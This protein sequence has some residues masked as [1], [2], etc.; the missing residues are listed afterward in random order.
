MKHKAYLS[1][2]SNLGDRIFNLK[3]A[4]QLLEDNPHIEV[5]LKS[6]FYTTA[7]IG[8][9]EQ[10]DFVNIVVLLETNLEPMEL[11]RV[12]GE[13]EEALKRV[14]VIHWGPRTIDLDIL[15]Y[16]GYEGSSER[17]TVPHPRMHERGF[18][19]IPLKELN[20][21]LVIRGKTVLDWCDILVDQEV[22]KMTDETW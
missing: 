10:D 4:V 3:Q 11:L 6:S 12:C 13:V 2:G 5:L 8:Y 22:R 18:V 9:L 14:R 7:P 15:W 19:M 20:S 1:L 17:L 16:E 21:S